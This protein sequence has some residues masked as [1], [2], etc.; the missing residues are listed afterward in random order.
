[1]LIFAADKQEL[2]ETDHSP[3]GHVLRQRG[4][5]QEQ[6]LWLSQEQSQN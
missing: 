6:K 3:R 2:Y 5:P 4:G 1:M